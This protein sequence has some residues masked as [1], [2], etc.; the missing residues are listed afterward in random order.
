[1]TEADFQKMV[2]DLCDFLGLMWHHETDSRKSKKGYPDL[3]IAGPRGVA[4]LEL[5]GDR[6]GSKA[7]PEQ[8]AW[9]ARLQGSGQRAFI[10]YPK[11]WSMVEDLL[12]KISGRRRT[13]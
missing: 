6:R 4:F 13:T 8:V 5:K 11:D 9:I 7:S 3:T 12:F 2:T 10:V 1:M